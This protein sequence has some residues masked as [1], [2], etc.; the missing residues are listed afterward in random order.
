MAMLEV[1]M[2]ECDSRKN[3]EAEARG[4]WRVFVGTGRER[5][6]LS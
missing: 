2:K 4:V 5:D 1:L 3:V 6:E